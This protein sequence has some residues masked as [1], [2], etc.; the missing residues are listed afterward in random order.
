MTH[1][2]KK[3]Q[4][5]EAPHLIDSKM[6]KYTT[7]RISIIHLGSLFWTILN[8]NLKAYLGAKTLPK[9]FAMKEMTENFQELFGT[10]SD[11]KSRDCGN[12]K[13]LVGGAPIKT[14]M[15]TLKP[16]R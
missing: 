10:L 2:K 6:N 5:L 13:R 3:N 7:Q 15:M 4:I 16:I 9:S 1:C 12:W 11:E 8:A 14:C